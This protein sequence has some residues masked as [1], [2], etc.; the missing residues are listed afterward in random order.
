M[1]TR[2]EK[3]HHKSCFNKRINNYLDN[4]AEYVHCNRCA[5][6]F[7]FDLALWDK[8]LGNV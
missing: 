2:K 5:K 8:R 7:D 6:Y 3:K 4:N 1:S